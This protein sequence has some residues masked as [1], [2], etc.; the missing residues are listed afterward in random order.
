M[1]PGRAPAPPKRSHFFTKTSPASV[2]QQV[3]SW[4]SLL[5]TLVSSLPN[6]RTL[7]F[8]PPRMDDKESVAVLNPDSFKSLIQH[9][10]NA[11]VGYIIGKSPVYTP[12]LQF[13]QKKWKPKADFRLFL[14]GNGF[15]TVK[16]DLEEDCNSVLE[17]GPWTME[18]R[19][20]ILRKWSPELRM[21]Q[22]RLS[23][24]PIWA[25][26]VTGPLEKNAQPNRSKAAL[27]KFIHCLATPVD[28]RP[29]FFFTTVYA[30]NISSERVALWED[31]VALSSQ[32]SG[33]QWIVGGDFNEA[34]QQGF[35]GSPLFVIAKK[36][37]HTKAILKHWNRTEFGPI[38]HKLQ[39]SRHSLNTAQD[40]LTSDP[41]NAH[42]ISNVDRA[43]FEY[44]DILSVEESFLRQKSRQLWLSEG[45]CNSQFFHAMV[46]DRISRNAIRQVQL[47]DSSFSSDPQV[48]KDHA[49]D[50]FLKL[51]N[52]KCST[53][54][55]SMPPF[56]VLSD[57]SK[58]DLCA[59]VSDEEI[60][61]AL[62]SLKP[63]SSPGPDG[64]S[65]H[66]F[67]YF[68]PLIKGDFIA[69][70][71][72]FFISGHLLKAINHSFIALIPKSKLVDS[73]GDFRPISLFIL[74]IKGDFESVKEI[75][76]K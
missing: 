71:R 45:D 32:I 6:E 14:H 52:R 34:W 57:G 66:F 73:F 13:L 53:P 8:I 23:S 12:F 39:D 38:Q 33:S 75:S 36:L 35:I 65:A 54:I 10:E 67:Q 27:P 16:F 44:L 43:K 20:F 58:L 21:E 42:L 28:G 15:F 7:S 68:W 2:G 47:P 25:S 3:Y 60:K 37:Q 51:L 63:L 24:I 41:L 62:F 9:W 55:P 49:V 64:F 29:P 76:L 56:S 50:Y 1:R 31:L 40:A 4:K 59:K 19:P 30:S 46:K 72:S 18:H 48:V 70:I 22:E 61:A 5:T 17:G 26:E 74:S 69:A 11:I